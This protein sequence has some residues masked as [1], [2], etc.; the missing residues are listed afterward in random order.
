MVKRAFVF[1][2]LM[3]CLPTQ[4]LAEQSRTFGDYTVHYV[5]FT[6][7]VLTPSVAKHYGI[8]RS[9]NRV[10]VN[11]S[12][13]KN[14]MGISG[15]PV[16]GRVEG[17]ATNLSE[18]LRELEIREFREEGAIYYIAETQI[19]NQETL[20]FDFTITPAEETETYHLSFQ[21]QFYTR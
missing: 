11:I 2:V 16:R 21:E 3:A 14:E 19:N 20:K 6:T 17:T 7:D 10:M 12:I 15:K 5:A 8:T 1:F 13:L 9:K 4:L 18:Q